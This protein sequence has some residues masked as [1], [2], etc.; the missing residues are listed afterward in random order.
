MIAQRELLQYAT[1]LDTEAETA[2]LAGVAVAY[3]LEVAQA[4]NVEA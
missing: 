3:R 4:L 2:A 1:A